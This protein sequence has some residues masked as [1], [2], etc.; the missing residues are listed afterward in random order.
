MGSVAGEGAGFANSG[1]SRRQ[2]SQV[3][4]GASSG[5]PQRRHSG[6]CGGWIEAAQAGQMRASLSNAKSALQPA[7]RNGKRKLQSGV[8][9][10][11]A[12]RIRERAAAVI[13]MSR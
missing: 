1:G 8:K 10:E 3:S 11:Y 9:T 13:A 5:I 2:R 6:A 4:P 7:H 12:I